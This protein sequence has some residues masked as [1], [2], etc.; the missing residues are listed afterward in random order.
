MPNE[1][2]FS[3]RRVA[4][5]GRSRATI[6]AAAVAAL[7]TVAILKPWAAS[8][9]AAPLT[10]RPSSPPVSEP[11]ALATRSVVDARRLPR[12]EAVE[13]AIDAHDDWGV[14]LVVDAPQSPVDGELL[15]LWQPATPALPGAI[16]SL[17]GDVTSL[18]T[19]RVADGSLRLAG[20][21]APA[22]A[23][24]DD[25]SFVVGRPLGRA[26]TLEV[27]T[28]AHRNGG[29]GSMLVRPRDGSRWPPGVYQF[30][31]QLAG[32]SAALTFAVFEAPASG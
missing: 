19:F 17:S 22:D 4:A 18:P 31:F 2:G 25:V 16:P 24:L 10:A 21:T 6:V 20:L 23:I 12:P 26:A 27:T 9:P 7:V 28:V 11:S 15:E 3:P 1:V 14:R 8:V 13:R 32:E 29:T 5:S 30:R